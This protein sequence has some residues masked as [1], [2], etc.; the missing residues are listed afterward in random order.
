MLCPSEPLL[1]LTLHASQTRISETVSPSQHR[2]VEIK[3]VEISVQIQKLLFLTCV[4]IPSGQHLG[5]PESNLILVHFC[6]Y[7]VISPIKLTHGRRGYL[8]N[9]SKLYIIKETMLDDRLQIKSLFLVKLK[10]SLY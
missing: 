8:G 7:I 6:S 4:F 9:P 2:G 10:G 1:G 3:R 5:I